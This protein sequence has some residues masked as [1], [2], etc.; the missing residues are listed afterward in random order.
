MSY[1]DIY[2][3]RVNR[4]GLD[5]QSRIQ[6][7]RERNF[8]L[9]LQKTIYRVD[10]LYN[11]EYVPGSLEK[12]KQD[13]TQTLHY[14]LTRTSTKIP[15]GTVLM[16]EDAYNKEIPWMVFYLEHIKASGYNRYILLRMTHFLKWIDKDG[17][18]RESWAYMVGKNKGTLVDNLKTGGVDTLYFE[19]NNYNFLIMPRNQ[20]IKRDL[21]LVIG[22]EPFQEHYRVTGY[23]LQSSEGVEYVTLDPVYEYDLTKPPEQQP[24]DNPDDYF[25]FNGGITE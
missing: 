15:N 11:G 23:D 13:E 10:F 18:E 17:I 24:E 5:Y 22:E 14:L 25:W 19:N 8:E 20:Y 21:Y 9:F 7:E 1:F 16:I 12:Y 6:G 4:Y 2:K 3:K